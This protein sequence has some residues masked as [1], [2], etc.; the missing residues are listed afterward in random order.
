MTLQIHL[1]L[2]GPRCGN[3]PHSFPKRRLITKSKKEKRVRL[4]HTGEEMQAE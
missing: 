2:P 4:P 3:G 1:T